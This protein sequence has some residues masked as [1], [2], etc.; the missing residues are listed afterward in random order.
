MLTATDSGPVKFYPASDQLLVSLRVCVCEW[1]CVDLN[2][3]EYCAIAPGTFSSKVL[4]LETPSVLL[5][6]MR[7][8]HAELYS[9]PVS[10]RDELL[11]IFF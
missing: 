4:A 11:D 8:G 2:S 7:S 10:W 5:T 1:V 9:F 6:V 3:H